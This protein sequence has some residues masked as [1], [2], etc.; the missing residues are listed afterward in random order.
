MNG[1][2]LVR[3]HEV[4]TVLSIGSKLVV[5]KRGFKLPGFFTFFQIT[6]VLTVIDLRS[7]LSKVSLYRVG[8]N[9]IRLTCDHSSC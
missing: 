6:G 4:E 9:L 3:T 5:E 8:T 7:I 1:L 2:L